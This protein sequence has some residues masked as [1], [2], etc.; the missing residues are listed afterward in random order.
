MIKYEKTSLTVSGLRAW[1]DRLDGDFRRTTEV[2]LTDEDGKKIGVFEKVAPIGETVSM[3][4]QLKRLLGAFLIDH[5]IEALE[6]EDTDGRSEDNS[7]DEVEAG[8]SGVPEDGT[9][10]EEK[11]PHDEAGDET[12]EGSP[13]PLP[14]GTDDDSAETTLIE[15]K[16]DAR[17]T[18]TREQSGGSREEESDERP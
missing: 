3:V 6:E 7:T 13:G 11:T 12:P 16:E 2:G 1:D 5:K 4:D 14:E 17:S 9:P 10:P 18:R 8:E 15:E